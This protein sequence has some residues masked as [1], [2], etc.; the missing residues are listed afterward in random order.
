MRVM[1]MV[2][3]TAAVLVHGELGRR[4]AGTQDLLR[5]VGL[6][7]DDELWAL[8]AAFGPLLP[9]QLGAATPADVRKAGLVDYWR[10]KG[11]PE[12]CHPTIGDDFVCI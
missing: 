7:T 4:D 11:W 3:L 10:A 8:T 5:A 2:V 12:F 1:P 9:T 6:H